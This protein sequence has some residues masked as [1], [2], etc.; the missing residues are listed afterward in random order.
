MN[1][2][3]RTEPSTDAT[4]FQFESKLS[5]SRQRFLACAVEHALFIGR[6]SP[7]DFVRHFSPEIIMEGMSQRP[8]LRA[9]ILSQTTG[10]KTRIAAKKSWKS[11]AEDLG[12]A[13]AE[14]ETT[15]ST[16][17]AVFEPDD[18]VRY[19]PQDK[20]WAFLTEG[21]FFNVAANQAASLRIAKQHIA[22]LLDRGLKDGLLSHRDIIEGVG[23]SELSARLPKVELGK[24]IESAIAAGRNK[25]PFADVDLWAALT[26]TALVDHVPLSQIWA[27]VLVAKL[28]MTHGFTTNTKGGPG[29]GTKAEPG[30]VASQP[31]SREEQDWVE[32][33]EDNT[34]AGDLISEDDFA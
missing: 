24:I 18:R 10:L 6:R 14:G 4:T 33:P 28:A 1:E 16:I 8:E 29:G 7:D 15:T 22:F 26:S 25:K 30:A 19:L 13:L 3:N 32:L 17:V 12:I 34:A 5:D 23:I 31:A 11:A 27:N 21:E 9:S 2:S 20:I